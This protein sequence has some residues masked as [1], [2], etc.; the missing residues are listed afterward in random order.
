MRLVAEHS[1]DRVVPGD[2]RTDGLYATSDHAELKFRDSGGGEHV[3]DLFLDAPDAAPADGHGRVFRFRLTRGADARS[4]AEALL[5]AAE[6]LD[7]TTPRAAVDTTTDRP[8]AAAPEEDT[9][10]TGLAARVISGLR[11][12]PFILATVRKSVALPIGAAETWLILVAM[13]LALLDR[14][15]KNRP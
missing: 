4:D 12:P 13:L 11:D 2:W 15:P 9:G 3:V 5:R 1:F 14:E 6:L 7:A 8:G 10:V